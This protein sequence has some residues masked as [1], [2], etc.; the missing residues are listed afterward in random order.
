MKKKLVISITW[1]ITIVISF[2]I[3]IIVQK[4]Q[5]SWFSTS[6][7]PNHQNIKYD[8]TSCVYW[9]KDFLN[10][11]ISSSID[12]IVQ[13]A[14]FYPTK[15]N[16][17]R[18]LLVSLHTWSGD[19]SQ[20]D[21]L[22]ILAKTKD[23]NYIHPDFRGPNQTNDACCSKLALTDIDDAIDY[24]INNAN[25]DT[26]NIFIVGVSGGG[27][28]TLCMFMKSKHKIKKFSSWVPISDL[29]AWYHQSLW[30]KNIYA[31]DILNCTN[32]KDNKLNMSIAKEKSP[33]YWDTPINKLSNS[34][35][36]IYAG[37]FDGIQGSVP[38]THS[39]NFYNK[40]LHDLGVNN[41]Q[42]YVSTKETLDLIENRTPVCNYGK[43]SDR[44]IYL[45]REYKNVKLIIFKGNHEMLPEY[46]FNSLME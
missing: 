26:A 44:K 30:R 6:K 5:N 38:I 8:S 29:P 4:N 36:E 20:Y 46:A 32:S 3:G 13:K 15:S 45:K 34:K 12:T 10:I 2:S 27:Y 40:I 35:L 25:V 1:T 28:A 23:W 39:I 37:V 31:D 14:Y 16:N 18:P 7:S 11:E 9:D 42:Y 24:A 19:F 17:S 21:T 41:E 43:I 33:V 22:A